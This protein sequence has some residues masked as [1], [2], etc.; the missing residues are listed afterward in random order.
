[1]KHKN[2]DMVPQIFLAVVSVILVGV[3][4]Y[5]VMNSIKSSTRLADTVIAKAEV[6]A[7]NYAEYE[8]AMYDGEELRGSEVVNFIKRE[9]G[10]Y[11]Y[12]DTAPIYVQVVNKISE[13]TYSHTHFN[14]KDIDNIRNFSSTE[15]YI[16]PTALFTGEVIRTENR[17]IV[18]VRF[19]QK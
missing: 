2:N 16:K 13:A 15:Y 10:D 9:L 11:S 4:V 19:T 5:Y 7:S 17:V 8:I 6:T 18:G 12:S 3:I 14:N 1:M